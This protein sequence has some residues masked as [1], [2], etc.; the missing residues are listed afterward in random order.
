MCPSPERAPDPELVAAC[1]RPLLPEHRSVSSVMRAAA[2]METIVY[3]AFSG[4]LCSQ[5]KRQAWD[6]HSEDS[7]LDKGSGP[8][9]K[10]NMVVTEW[11]IGEPSNRRVEGGAKKAMAMLTIN[12]IAGKAQVYLGHAS[13]GDSLAKGNL[14]RPPKV[15][16]WATLP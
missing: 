16:A 11:S 1:P 12:E 9:R 3:F 15:C 13:Q 8:A 5:S 10:V 7:D 14:P 4:S 2:S 6:F